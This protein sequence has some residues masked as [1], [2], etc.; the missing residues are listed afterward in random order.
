MSV[1]IDHLVLAAP[2]LEDGIAHVEDL[3]GATAAL[4]G[5]HPGMGT[6][7]ALL[8]LGDETYLEIIAPDPA[9]PEP[10]GGRPFGVANDGPIELRSFAVRPAPGRTID[11]IVDAAR[12][13][14]HDP[15]PIAP[16]SRTRPDGV[17]LRWRLTMPAGVGGDLRIPFVIDWGET[18]S[19]ALSS[20]AGGRLLGLEVGHPNPERLLAVYS[21]LGLSLPVVEAMPSHL[22]ARIDSPAGE[23]VLGGPATEDT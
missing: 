16:M 15:G 17:E 20:P 6:H 1:V 13:T 18:P 4:G 3:T 5:A 11:H 2:S 19:P 21:A 8:A 9:Q 23:V 22:L 10:A 14:G 12:S 7:N